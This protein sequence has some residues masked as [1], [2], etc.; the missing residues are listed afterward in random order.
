MRGQQQKQRQSANRKTKV[1][2]LLCD[3]LTYYFLLGFLQPPPEKP[4]KKLKLRS[5]TSGLQV[6]ACDGSN[7][8]QQKG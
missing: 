5:H 8:Q 6:A 2:K 7:L 3:I 4:H 1:G